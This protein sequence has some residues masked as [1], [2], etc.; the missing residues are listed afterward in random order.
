MYVYIVN[1][2]VIILMNKHKCRFVPRHPLIA[3]QCCTPH[4][5]RDLSMYSIE[6][7]AEQA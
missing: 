1:M 3:F 6:K 4:P 2:K 5:P 7:L